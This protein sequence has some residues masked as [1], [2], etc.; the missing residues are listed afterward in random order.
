MLLRR[1]LAAND[2]DGTDGGG[3]GGF[4]GVPSVKINTLGTQYKITSVGNVHGGVTPDRKFSI[5]SSTERKFSDTSTQIES[6]GVS[7]E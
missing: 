7:E 3:G 6:E 5:V 4:G 2:L 1:R